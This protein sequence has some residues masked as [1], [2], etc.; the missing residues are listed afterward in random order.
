MSKVKINTEVIDN[1]VI[2][3]KKLKDV[4]LEN[5]KVKVPNSKNDAGKAHTE[6]TSVCTNIQNGWKS[7]DL[8]I[9]KTIKFLNGESNT[10]KTSDKLSSEKLKI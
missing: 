5:E 3:L 10:V 4:C 2:E 1:A 7:L 8:L 9:D 6:I